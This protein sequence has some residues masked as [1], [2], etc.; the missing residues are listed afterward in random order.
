[1]SS[2]SLGG[3]LH[4]LIPIFSN[5]LVRY[6]VS[7]GLCQ[8]S[9]PALL[10]EELGFVTMA[11]WYVAN[12][13]VTLC[14]YESHS[15]KYSSDQGCMWVEGMYFNSSLY[16]GFCIFHFSQCCWASFWL[17]HW[18]PNHT[19]SPLHCHPNTQLLLA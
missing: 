14:V 16:N 2:P 15:V 18:Y 4:Q 7:P 11:A 13:V 5:Q 10:G 12:L 3:D 19:I 8:T 9:V 6:T 1:M 17:W